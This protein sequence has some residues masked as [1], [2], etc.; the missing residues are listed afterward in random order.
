MVASSPT[1]CEGIWC[2]LLLLMYL[3]VLP[4]PILD[5]LGGLLTGLICGAKFRRLRL[6]HGV[7]IGFLI[8]MG[9]G[10]TRVVLPHLTN[11]DQAALAF[12]VIPVVAVPCSTVLACWFINRRI[13]RKAL[14][15]GADNERRPGLD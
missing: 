12:I 11:P 4:I 9:Y 14:A 7:G 3:I 8:G 15:D 1:V 5:P 13:A 2:F 6:R 10:V